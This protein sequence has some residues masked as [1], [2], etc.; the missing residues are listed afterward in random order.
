MKKVKGTDGREKKNWGEDWRREGRGK[1]KALWI[2]Q[3]NER[4]IGANCFSL[5]QSAWKNLFPLHSSHQKCSPFPLQ[6]LST[7]SCYRV[8]TVTVTLLKNKYNNTMLYNSGSDVC[9][10]CLKHRTK[11]FCWL[12]YWRTIIAA[13]ISVASLWHLQHRR[14]RCMAGHTKERG[15]TPAPCFPDVGRL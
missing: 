12:C 14:L 5:F 9:Q 6:S 7:C 4:V 13:W 11:L 2:M 10:P 8:L 15:L 3:H 1:S